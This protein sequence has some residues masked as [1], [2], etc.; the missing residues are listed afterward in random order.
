MKQR[1]GLMR[2]WKAY[3][4]PLAKGAEQYYRERGYI[5]DNYYGMQ[6]NG[7]H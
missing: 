4:V 1:R 6:N 2:V 7:Q 3:G 5:R